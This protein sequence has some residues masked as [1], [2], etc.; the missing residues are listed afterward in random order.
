MGNHDTTYTVKQN[1][2]KPNQ[3]KQKLTQIRSNPQIQLPIYGKYKQQEH[4]EL[5]MWP[6]RSW[7]WEMIYDKQL[8][9]FKT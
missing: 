1:K 7:P 8:P 4:T 9:S 3:N 2:T 5:G 6:V